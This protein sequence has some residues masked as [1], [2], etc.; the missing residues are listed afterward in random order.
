MNVRDLKEFLNQYP[1]DMELLNERYSDYQI[2]EVD[3]FSVVHGVEVDDFSV[4]HGVEK[5]GWVM[6]SHP[7]MSVE[8]KMAEK[9]YLLLRG[10]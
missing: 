3:D 4:V 7:T 5:D 8:N 6:K 1:D 9:S 10:N 2:I